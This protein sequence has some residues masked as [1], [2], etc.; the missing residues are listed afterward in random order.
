M[1]SKVLVAL[2]ETQLSVRAFKQSL[3]IAK[4]FDAEL[5]LL[6]VVSPLEARY[7]NTVS[8]IGSGYG[9]NGTNETAE[10]EWQE[11]VTNRLDY[12]QSLVN[13]AEDVGVQTDLIQ[14]IGQPAQQI[15]ESAKEWQA[16][17]IVIGS[18]GRKGL[19]ELIVGSVSNYVSHHVP[20]AVLLVHQ[21]D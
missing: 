1:Y 11:L 4:A 9:G 10:A 5:M 18:H 21:Q 12:L 19:N 17:L 2:D 15:C 3:S 20:C 16:D 8:L 14:E 13:E 7:Q 6:N